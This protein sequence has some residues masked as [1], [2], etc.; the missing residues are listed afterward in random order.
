M[1]I[2]SRSFENVVQFKC[3]GMILTNQN[4]IQEDIKRKLNSGNA[5]YH[6]VQNLL[7]PYLLSKIV[8]IRIIKAKILPVVQCWSLTVREKHIP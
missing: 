4:M 3:M 6:S 2:R 1:K 7:S 8:K 5:C